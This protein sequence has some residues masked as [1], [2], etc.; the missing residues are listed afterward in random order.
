MVTMLEIHLLGP[1]RVA[2]GGSQVEA[3]RW[4]RRSATLLLKLLALQPHHQLHREQVIE[5][6]WP[7]LEPQAAINNLHKT[8]H[9]ARRALEPDLK[10]G[11]DSRFIVTHAQQIKLCAPGKLWIDV[12]A[13]QQQAAQALKGTDAQ[14]Y[15]EALALYDGGLL[16][17]DLYEDW[18]VARREQLRAL[19]QDLL[20]DLT[21]L[22][23][24]QGRYGQS[25]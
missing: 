2:V 17:E 23:E 20:A 16:I 13:F 10:A 21:R 14:A 18:T 4:R 24:T 7:E 11:A 19:H 15:E 9:A 5:T 12:E 25:I 6:L 22:Y 3:R 1:F 8:I